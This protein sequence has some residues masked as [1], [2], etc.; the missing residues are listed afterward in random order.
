MEGMRTDIYSG[1]VPRIARFPGGFEEVND[2][3]AR[4]VRP[5]H[6]GDAAVSTSFDTERTAA[7]RGW[8]LRHDALQIGA[9]KLIRLAR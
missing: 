7:I 8:L 4:C 6:A 1:L 2:S 3:D 5:S 9:I